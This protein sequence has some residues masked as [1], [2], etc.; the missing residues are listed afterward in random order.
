MDGTERHDELKLSVR[1]NGHF[2]PATFSIYRLQADCRL[3]LDLFSCVR[4]CLLEADME[5]APKR[6]N[7]KGFECE[8]PVIDMKNPSGLSPK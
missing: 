6:K 2:R 1:V 8:S 4:I 3:V 7:S 5:R